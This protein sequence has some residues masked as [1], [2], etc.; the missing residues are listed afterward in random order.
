MLVERVIPTGLRDGSKRRRRALRTETSAPRKARSLDS[1]NHLATS[2]SESFAD[3]LK[4]H[5]TAQDKRRKL[6][7]IHTRL[8]ESLKSAAHVETYIAQEAAIES[9][10]GNK[11]G[12]ADFMKRE[13]KRKWSPWRDFE[14]VS[15]C[16]T[17]WAAFRA[18]CC[19]DSA[20][21]AVP[22][23][24]NHRLC[25]LCN[26]HRASHYRERVQALFGKIDNP[27]LLTLTVP[28][29]KRLTRETISALRKRLKAFLK[30]N[31]ALLM[32]GVYSI[33]ITRNRADRTWHPHI[34]VL[35]DVAG[36]AQRLTFSDFMDR[37]WALE[38]SWFVLTQGKRTGKR[39]WEM[40]D[41]A[42]WME[43]LDPR[44]RGWV[45]N[46]YNVQR[47]AGNREGDRR[48]VDLRP[49]STDKK[50]AYE[51]MKY[52]TKVAYFVDD[53]R[54][55]SEF[56]KAVKGIRAIQTFGSC[57][58]FKLEEKPVQSTL[59]CACG[60]NKFESIGIV[61][62]GM[63]LMDEKGCWHVRDD[64]P[65]H[66]RLAKRCRGGTTGRGV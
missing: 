9:A 53:P 21:V 18:S 11:R 60:L 37:K 49:V 48:S 3:W 56:L 65:V 29:C 63:V 27:Q 54:A 43:V 40:G 38:Y 10:T 17:Q 57:Y 58:G 39:R 51:V 12:F 1:V 46:P 42:A 52:M 25:P 35:V 44:S 45:M 66:G 14:R 13:G 31:K 30:D 33:E 50:A 6:Y 5:E 26:A 64:A 23:G 20:A 62:L 24:C 34:H 61:G 32:G 8:L 22:I 4:R 28:N 15:M 19:E 41:F 59:K 36:P 47:L 55:L 2:D 16:Q 7:S